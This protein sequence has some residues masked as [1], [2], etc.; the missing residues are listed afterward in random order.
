MFVES[1]FGWL[2]WFQWNRKCSPTESVT[3]NRLHTRLN[4]L[5]QS[6]LRS[7]LRCSLCHNMPMC[8]HRFSFRFKLDSFECKNKS[9]KEIV[10]YAKRWAENRIY[11]EFSSVSSIVIFNRNELK[12]HN[13]III[14]GSWKGARECGTET[15]SHTQQSQWW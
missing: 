11:N 7:D 14:H 5:P 12:T 8:T 9:S 15:Q 10:A 2:F 4:L 3:L 1:I 6:D 13:L